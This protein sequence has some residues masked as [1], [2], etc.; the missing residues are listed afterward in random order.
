MSRKPISVVWNG[1]D[2]DSISDLAEQENRSVSTIW[3]C[4]NLD[5]PLKTRKGVKEYIDFKLDSED[6]IR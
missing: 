2:Y 6:F 4:L 5:T 1:S 3:K